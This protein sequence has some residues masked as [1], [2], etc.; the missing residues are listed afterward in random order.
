VS[1]HKVYEILPELR[2]VALRRKHH[3][4]LHISHLFKQ[5]CQSLLDA[6]SAA[7]EEGLLRE[8]PALLADADGLLQPVALARLEEGQQTPRLVLGEQA[9]H[10]FVVRASSHLVFG[11]EFLQILV[12]PSRVAILQRIDNSIC[13]HDRAVFNEQRASLTVID[14][15]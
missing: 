15:E 3:C 1:A 5:Y 13:V 7:K 6:A 2:V 4:P 14:L 12:S 8:E 10:L 9:D 11:G